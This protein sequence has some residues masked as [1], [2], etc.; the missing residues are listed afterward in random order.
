MNLNESHWAEIPAGCGSRRWSN[1]EQLSRISLS[2]AY[3]L[4]C[5]EDDH[6]RPE[7]GMGF[8]QFN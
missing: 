1:D 4:I 2:G 7:K 5:K 8:L 3:L 6:S